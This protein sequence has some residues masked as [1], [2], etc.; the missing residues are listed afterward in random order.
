MRLYPAIRATAGHYHTAL[1]AP[2]HT[3]GTRG[4]KVEVVEIVGEGC[5]SPIALWQSVMCCRRVCS[6]CS[7]A[8]VC[9]IP[10]VQ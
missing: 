1:L 8:C 3:L 2:P 4:M 6:S 7:T 5:D 10:T 9:K